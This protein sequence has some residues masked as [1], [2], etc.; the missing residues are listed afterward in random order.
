MKVIDFFHIRKK[1]SSID[2]TRAL[3]ESLPSDLHNRL[4]LHSHYDLNV[5]F[6]LGGMHTVFSRSCHSIEELNECG[7][8]AYSF[9]SPIFDSISKTGYL[10]R[11]NLSDSELLKAN[12]KTP[13]IAL[14]GITPRHFQKLFESK[15]AGAALLGYLWSP[16]E[17]RE[18]KI[19]VIRNSLNGIKTNSR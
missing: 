19:K 13:V 1:K 17:S 6:P 12:V 14:G 18:T 16:K 4:V 9:L 8:F 7:K 3:L 11:F 15:F 2:Y 10:S 5:E